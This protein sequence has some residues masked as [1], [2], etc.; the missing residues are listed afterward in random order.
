VNRPSRLCA[1]GTVG[2][3]RV[4]AAISYE[5]PFPAILHKAL[6]VMRLSSGPATA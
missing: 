2:A 4:G 5:R 1:A 3:H 6:A